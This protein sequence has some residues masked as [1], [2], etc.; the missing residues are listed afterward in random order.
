[1][2]KIMEAL[3]FQLLRS[4]TDFGKICILCHNNAIFE[5]I[6]DILTLF[7]KYI[8]GQYLSLADIIYPTSQTPP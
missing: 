7:L 4:I 8:R 3:C 2:L 5:I 1:M 6:F